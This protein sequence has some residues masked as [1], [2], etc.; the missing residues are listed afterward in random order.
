MLES[1]MMGGCWL[2]GGGGGC[3]KKLSYLVILLCIL[4]NSNVYKTK[5]CKYLSELCPVTLV[6]I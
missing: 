5:L 2:G 1:K 6:P 3:K 4:F